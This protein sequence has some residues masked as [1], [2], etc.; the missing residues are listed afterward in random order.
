M[1]FCSLMRLSVSRSHLRGRSDD[2]AHATA[3]TPAWETILV[4]ALALAGVIGTLVL[5]NRRADQRDPD[6][7]AATEA[8]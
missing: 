4:A 8:A 7:G 2:D 6:L 5:A 1:Q 3:T